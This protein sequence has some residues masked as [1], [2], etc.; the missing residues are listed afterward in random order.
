MTGIVTP[1]VPAPTDSVTSQLIT[2]VLAGT[3]LPVL[4]VLSPATVSFP[5]T[6]GQ[7]YSIT[8]IDVNAN[9]DSL[10]SPATT[11]IVPTIPT[12]GVPAT[13]GAPSVA[14]TNP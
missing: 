9:G 7:T 13:P 5:C 3:T 2:V 1:F 10:A 14:F 4:T 8:E 6:A 11:G 12:T